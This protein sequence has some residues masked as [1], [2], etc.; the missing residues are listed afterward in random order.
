MTRSHKRGVV[1][2]SVIKLYFTKEECP[3]QYGG[4]EGEADTKIDVPIH[5]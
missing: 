5:V 2:C 1:T 3:H 4:G